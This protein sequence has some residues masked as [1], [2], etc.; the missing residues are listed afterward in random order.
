MQQYIKNFDIFGHQVHFKFNKNKSTY[1]TLIGGICTIILYSI[2]TVY[3][4]FKA[5]D[6]VEKFESS[7]QTTS[8]Q[9]NQRWDFIRDDESDVPYNKMNITL[10]NHIY[11]QS[12]GM[13][14]INPFDDE[15]SRY[16]DV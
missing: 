14:S 1:N 12:E 10:F 9:I 8:R 4:I 15:I 16:I 3:I 5:N 13:K 7:F 2:M 11:K 6:F